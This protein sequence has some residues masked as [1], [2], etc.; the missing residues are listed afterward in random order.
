MR[1][2]L[3]NYKWTL[4]MSKKSSIELQ[5]KL[6]QNKHSNILPNMFLGNVIHT[7]EQE[8]NI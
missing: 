7:L 1:E 6:F 2:P 3:K 8:Y 4:M 5:D